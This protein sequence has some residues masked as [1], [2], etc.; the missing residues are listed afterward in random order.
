[1]LKKILTTGLIFL[2]LNGGVIAQE[3][4]KKD[5]DLNDRANV[6]KRIQKVME[7]YIKKA[8]KEQKNS[9]E[10]KLLTLE[11][12]KKL[13]TLALSKKE[14][15][16]RIGIIK[17]LYIDIEDTKNLFFLEFDENGDIKKE[18]REASD[19]ILSRMGE[20]SK[21]V[22]VK[23]S[24]DKYIPLIKYT[25]KKGDTLKKLL[26]RTYPFD[27]KPI[28]LQIS[29]RIETLVKINK[30]IIKMNYIY[31]GQIIYIPIF[32]DNPSKEEVAINILKQQER[33]LEKEREKEL[34]EKSK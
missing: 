30:T 8:N 4:L 1:M 29:E 24:N 12:E 11:L 16:L 5:I 10:I 17:D 2:S 7:Y 25:V 34:E 15:D 9:E 28:W 22:K 31:P 21:L 23:L 19:V 6:Q 18:I 3:N 14:I 33:K 27:Y 32:N 26:M 13:K 20:G